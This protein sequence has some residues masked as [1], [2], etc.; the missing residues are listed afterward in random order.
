VPD[1]G[2]DGFVSDHDEWLADDGEDQSDLEDLRRLYDA[3]FQE[4]EVPG[5]PGS[6]IAFMVPSGR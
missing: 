1:T 6:Y 2:Q 4:V 3:D 5:F